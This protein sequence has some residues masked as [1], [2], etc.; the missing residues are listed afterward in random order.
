[1]AVCS[2]RRGSPEELYVLFADSKRLILGGIHVVVQ[3]DGNDHVDLWAKGEGGEA[4]GKR[5]V[6]GKKETPE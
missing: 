3:N 5:E 6:I 4:G 2:A 1:M